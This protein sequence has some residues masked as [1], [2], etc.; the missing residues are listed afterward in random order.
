MKFQLKS[1]F[2]PTGDQ[3]TAIKQLTGNLKKDVKHQVLLGVTGSGKTFTMANV[4]EKIQKPTLII[5]PNKTLAAQLYQEFK[6]FFPNNA[7]HYFVSYYDYYQ[8]EAY[9]PQTDTY[10]EKDAKINEEIDRMRHSAVQDLISRDDVIVVASVSCIYNIGS[11]ENYKGISFE[12]KTGQKIKRSEF[13]LKLSDLQYQRND[14]GFSAQGANAQGRP[15][16]GVGPASGWKPGMFRVRGDLVEVNIVTGTEILRVEFSNDKISKI[17]TSEP[18]VSTNYKLLTTNYR[19]FPAHF[20][21][22]PHD[23]IKLAIKN[24]Q[25]ELTARLKELKK[26]KKLLEAERLKQR[27]NYDI[28]ML[29]ETGFCYGIENYSSH[30][31][32]RPQGQAPFSL[33]DYFKIKDAG[34]LIFIDESHI[35]I[36]Q[37]RAMSIGDKIRKETLINFGFRLPSAVDNRHLK[38]N[39]FEKINEEVKLS[40]VVKKTN[41]GGFEVYIGRNAEMN[42]ILTTEIARP[43]DLW[44][45]ASGHT[46]SHVVIRIEDEYPSKEVI[47]QVAK[48]AAE[49]SKGSGKVKVVYTEARNVT[50]TDKNKIG[51]VQVDYSKSEIIEVNK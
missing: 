1:N 50:K 21:L 47:K 33:V 49:N 30:L 51:Q 4:I 2:K 9:I 17:S 45:H 11:P 3:P 5:S 19:L 48:L 13:I 22:A 34:S 41:I 42:D 43:S 8:P 24:I 35:S 39:E 27:T 26:Q 12:I 10:I 36:S 46:G 6:E 44:F 16:S 29:Q 32:F 28:E 38:F 15:A 40:N 20:W 18:S 37:I 25:N 31:E 14:L 7:V 23:K